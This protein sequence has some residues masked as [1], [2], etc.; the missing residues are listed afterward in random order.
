[1]TPGRDIDH[2]AERTGFGAEQGKNSSGVAGRTATAPVLARN[3]VSF[4]W[5]SPR[6]KI[7]TGLLSAM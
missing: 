5:S 2:G 6:I 3:L 7:S 4:N 1:L